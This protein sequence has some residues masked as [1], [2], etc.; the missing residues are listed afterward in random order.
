[1]SHEPSQRFAHPSP[2]SSALCSPKWVRSPRLA[3]SHLPAAARCGRL[4]MRLRVCR[5]AD[6][7]PIV[8]VAGFCHHCGAALVAGKIPAMG[9]RKSAGARML[10]DGPS[11]GRCVLAALILSAGDHN[12]GCAGANF[13]STCGTPVPAAAVSPAVSPAP[14]APQHCPRLAHGVCPLGLGT[15]ICRPSPPGSKACLMRPATDASS[16]VSHSARLVAWNSFTK[17]R[18]HPGGP[19]HQPR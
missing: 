2:A 19:P 6:A 4:Q 14:A 17:S 11:C 8:C 10:K 18:D 7:P 15:Y 5:G 13:C 16:S 3:D 9:L 12:V 1:M